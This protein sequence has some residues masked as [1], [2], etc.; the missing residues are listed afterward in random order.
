MHFTKRR[1]Q[2]PQPPQL[3]LIGTQL[4]YS[5]N[6][7]YLGVEL[8]RTLLFRSHLQTIANR[9]TRRL[10]ALFP[11]LNSS[12]LTMKVGLHV[13]LMM[14]RPMLAY[15]VPTWRHCANTYHILLQ[16]VQNWAARIITGHS[17]F[18]RI[19]HLHEGYYYQ[20]LMNIYTSYADLLEA[21][22][23]TSSHFPP[24][25]GHCPNP[26]RT[27]RMPQPTTQTNNTTA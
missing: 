18:T 3:L 20:C 10:L 8:D 23:P 14:I 25:P 1:Q 19:A 17:R 26:C 15:V 6:E 16:R 27:H 21:N 2:L 13:Y 11:F 4:S 5:Q 7:K 24:H 12:D 22:V 9:G